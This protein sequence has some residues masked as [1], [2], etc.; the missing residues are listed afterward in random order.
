MYKLN[1]AKIKEKFSE[2]EGK[3]ERI[4]GVRGTRSG[5]GRDY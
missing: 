4:K 5:D 3:G 2:R 1:L